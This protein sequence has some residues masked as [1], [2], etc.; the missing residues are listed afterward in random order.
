MGTVTK[1]ASQ[2]RSVIL[3]DDHPIFRLGLR[4]LLE[5]L[6]INIFAEASDG[7]EAIELVRKLRPQFV[8]MDLGMPG[9]GG[10]EAIQQIAN[11][12]QGTLSIAL[13]MYTDV[14]RVRSVLRAGA[15]GYVVKDS[16]ASEVA[17]ALAV[18]ERGG[19]YLSPRI[20]AAVLSEH[21][22][23][24]SDAEAKTYVL[25]PRER[26]VLQFIA[27]GH[28]TKQIA[29][30]MHLSPKTVETY[31]VRLMRKLA[32]DNIAGLTKFAIKEGIALLHS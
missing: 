10:I 8:L 6:G 2:M 19:I 28:S 27:D 21:P 24:L 7:N 25:T 23:G 11:D 22:N 17:D 12:G 13:S 1:R 26:Q 14:A 20:S 3:A 29:L 9:T 4:V 5:K 16:A 30:K 32:I 18:T 31:R 15:V